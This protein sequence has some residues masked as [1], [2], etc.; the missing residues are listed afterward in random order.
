MSKRL[1]FI[2]FIFFALSICSCGLFGKN[3]AEKKFN[4]VISQL[5]SSI[6]LT[7]T[8]DLELPKSINGVTLTWTSNNP[9][10]ITNEGKVTRGN[11]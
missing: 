1:L 10:V 4:E 7:V 3:E 5:D 2:F 11:E 6:N 8:E 9:D